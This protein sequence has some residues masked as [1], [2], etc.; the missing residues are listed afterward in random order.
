MIIK[1]IYLPRETANCTTFLTSYFND[2]LP[3]LDTSSINFEAVPLTDG[4]NVFLSLT[5]THNFQVIV[6]I[7]P[8]PDITLS[9]K[10]RAPLNP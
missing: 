7:I 3:G 6:K 9:A 8:L 4:T 5:G 1:L 2:K 10:S